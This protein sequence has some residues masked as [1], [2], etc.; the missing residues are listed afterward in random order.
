[1]LS[2]ISYESRLRDVANQL[3]D[4][5]MLVFAQPQGYRNATVESQY[6]QDSWFYYL[7][8]FSE[9]DAALLIRGFKSPEDEQVI[10]FLRDKDA[11]AELWNGRRLGVEAAKSRSGIHCAYAWDSLW[12]KLPELL[13]GARGLHYSLGLQA[14][15]DRRVIETLRKV[16]LLGQRTNGSLMPIHDTLAISGAMR[17]IKQPEEIERMEAAASATRKAFDE[18]LKVLQP[19]LNER[20]IHG[21]LLGE[22]LKNGAEME[23][24]G[25]IVAAGDNACCLHYR[26][27]NAPLVSGELL[28]IDAG[29]QV[30][31]YASDVTRTFPINGKFTPAQKALYQVTLNAQL[32]AFEECKPGSNWQKVQ[33]RCFRVLT[34]GLIELGFIQESVDDALA[35]NL[36]KVFCPHSISHWIGLDVHDAGLYAE[37]GE[38][39]PFRPGMYFSVEPG[40]YIPKDYDKVPAEY[41]GIGVRIEDDVLITSEGRRILTAGIPKSVEDIEERLSTVALTKSR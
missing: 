19:G 7:T 15:N 9:T 6:R 16:R 31:N 17:V 41:R 34:E 26:D 2:T 40:I 3:G 35:K 36:H 27:N 10:L 14:D 12:T 33:N 11:L 18:V 29:S 22:F 32:A 4:Q 13:Q 20:T 24:Y 1:M 37:N 25:S 8:G 28:L 38:P 21:V 5:A 30:D 39:V 23:A